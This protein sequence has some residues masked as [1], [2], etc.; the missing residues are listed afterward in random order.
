MN[1]LVAIFGKTLDEME[2]FDQDVLA[3]TT[4]AL[5][6]IVREVDSPRQRRTQEPTGKILHTIL[7]VGNLQRKEKLFQA[8]AVRAIPNLPTFDVRH[9]SNLAYATAIADTVPRLAD[10]S[11][12]FDH[13]A[14]KTV[15]R[16]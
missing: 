6:K 8:I 1:E 12:L 7:I 11:T 15:F 3:Q 5:A 2:T 4:L 13:V 9:L 10:G 16:S 14:K